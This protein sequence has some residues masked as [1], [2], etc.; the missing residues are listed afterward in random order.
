MPAVRW[1]HSGV[2]FDE[3][4]GGVGTATA[5]ASVYRVRSFADVSNLT[6]TSVLTLVN[7]ISFGQ[8]VGIECKADAGEG[9]DSI[10]IQLNTGR[11]FD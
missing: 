8:N 11:L 1:T 2:T 9:P 7:P 6:A 3:T 5:A 10:Q 4:G